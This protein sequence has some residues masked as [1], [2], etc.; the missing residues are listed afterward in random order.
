MIRLPK[1]SREFQLLLHEPLD[2][3]SGYRI[4][5]TGVVVAVLVFAGG[6]SLWWSSDLSGTEASRSASHDA[7]QRLDRAR[8]T[9]AELPAMRARSGD[10]VPLARWTVADALRELTALAAQ[11]GLRIGMIEPSAQ[12]GE[13]LEIERPLK[14][15]AE[16]SFGEIRQFLDALEG[17]PRLVIPADVQMKRVTNA[18]ALEATLRVFEDLPAITRPEPSR[19]DAFAIDPFGVKNG[20]GVGD[21]GAMLLVGTLRAQRRAMAL[22]E[23]AA[24]VDGFLQGQMVG[25]ERLGNVRSRSIELSRPDGV[26]RTIGF[27][28][29]RP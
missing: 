29:D 22:V 24:G 15:R 19:R 7:Q 2:A 1:S 5:L 14:F 17:L 9:A 4:A 18:L 13:G 11:S 6:V 25:D 20:T 3:W 28:D 16:G 12:K 8:A 27:A 26:V 10:G 23:T 21:G